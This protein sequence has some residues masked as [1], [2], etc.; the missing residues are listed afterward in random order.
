[1]AVTLKS[2][3]TGAT[4]F[5]A[6]IRDT[7][8]IGAFKRFMSK[9]PTINDKLMNKFM[10][11]VEE[12]IRLL[13][14]LTTRP[15]F[16]QWITEVN[17][18]LSRKEEYT[19]AFDFYIEHKLHIDKL[20]SVYGTPAY[21]KDET[22][23][24]FLRISTF[25]K[26]EWYPEMKPNRCINPRSIT[27]MPTVGPSYADI[28]KVIFSLPEFIKYVPIKDRPKYILERLSNSGSRCVST[29]Y[30]SFENSFTMR[31]QEA[32]E[33]KLYK[34]MLKLYPDLYNLCH[35]QC[36]HNDVHCS[37]MSISMDA[38]RMSGEMCTSLGNGFTNL[39]LMK[40]FCYKH[41]ITDAQGVIEGDDGLF[42]YHGPSL[43][44]EFFNQL[45]FQIEIDER[46][47]NESSFCGNI[48]TEKSLKTLVNPLEAIATASYSMQ[49]VGA[50]DCELNKLTYLMGY[51]LLC[52]YGN[53]PIVGA[54][55]RMQIRTTILNDP[56]VRN[57][58]LS[59]FKTSRKL[60][61]WSREIL[62]KTIYEKVLDAKVEL[63]DRM[64]IERLYDIPVSAQ[65]LIEKQLDQSTGWVSSDIL[66]LL[67]SV[68]HPEWVVNYS[69]IEYSSAVPVRYLTYNPIKRSLNY[70]EGEEVMV[71]FSSFY[72]G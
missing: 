58:A 2:G 72:D 20:A 1:M 28:S 8:L 68:K 69:K 32:V 41:D 26:S 45:G 27:Y 15:C 48:F 46:D 19:K 4:L 31:V 52:Q 44:N 3:I 24:K 29:D 43:D 42:T 49:G 59:Y 64:L 54:F 63:E 50:R 18:P 11:F 10:K 62:S 65:L 51:S 60:D 53:C 56:H 38:A 61:W 34:H 71:N 55:A 67:Y 9:P 33:M 21:K 30:K 6:D 70:V 40:F 57:K 7:P 23:E 39:M 14:H 16:E 22:F 5:T 13:P 66:D 12:Q 35:L 17:Q 47:L 36:I 25:I 37:S